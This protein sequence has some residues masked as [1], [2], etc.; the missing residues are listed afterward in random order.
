MPK[1]SFAVPRDAYVRALAASQCGDGPDV[2]TDEIALAAGC[3]LKLPE[4]LAAFEQ[5]YIARI[6]PMLR[7]QG[8]S[9]DKVDEAKQRVR[10][11]LLVARDG[12]PTIRLC[13]YAGS[14]RL[15]SLVRV[16]AMRAARRVDSATAYD[17]MAERWSYDPASDHLVGELGQL[18]KAAFA[19]AL[20]Q[21]N[22]NEKVL[23]RMVF[24]ENLTYREVA[25]LFSTSKS[26]VCRQL[27]DIERRLV[28]HLSAVWHEQTA[29]SLREDLAEIVAGQLDLSI[30]RLLRES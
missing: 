15:A 6:P 22:A 28:K 12:E 21:C 14:G 17:E 13:R 23:L 24:V 20:G 2:D 7:G 8:F 5:E 29:G 9:A 26:K 10:T 19:V 25:E 30:S 18:F 11:D 4:A 27:A 16:C 1:W 3:D